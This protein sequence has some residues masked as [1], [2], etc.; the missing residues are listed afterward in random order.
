MTGGH[1]DETDAEEGERE[2]NG[3]KDEKEGWGRK[4]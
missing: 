1:E 4:K 3:G 2:G